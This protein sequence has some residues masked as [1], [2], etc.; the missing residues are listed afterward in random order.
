MRENGGGD[1]D[2][3]RET[4]EVKGLLVHHIIQQLVI[5]PIPSSPSLSSTVQCILLLLADLSRPVRHFF[6]NLF[7]FTSASTTASHENPL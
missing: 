7:L 5:A 1:D 6:K 2:D 4:K 3:E